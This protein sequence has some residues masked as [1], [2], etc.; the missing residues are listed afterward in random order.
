MNTVYE[1]KNSKGQT[2]FLH[3]MDITLK[4]TGRKQTIYYF[5]K[6]INADRALPEIPAG[7]VVKE[8]AKTGLPLLKKA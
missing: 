8:S 3:T 6:A 2:Y 7:F 5:A 1:Y 4:G